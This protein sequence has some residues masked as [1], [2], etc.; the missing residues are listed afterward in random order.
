MGVIMQILL[1]DDS[2]LTRKEIKS[3]LDF[4]DCNED[5]NC[6]RITIVGCGGD[7]ILLTPEIKPISDV[8]K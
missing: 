5:S 4:I 3:L 8:G 7:E 6:Y 1:N 2:F